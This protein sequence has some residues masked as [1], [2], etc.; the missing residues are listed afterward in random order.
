MSSKTRKFRE[1]DKESL[2]RRDIKIL[3]VI[4]EEFLEQ[5]MDIK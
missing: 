2:R 4:L 5:K 3:Y 1:T